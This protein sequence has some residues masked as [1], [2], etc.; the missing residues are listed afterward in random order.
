MKRIAVLM[1]AALLA[2]CTKV[3][4]SVITL[5]YGSQ[6]S[7]GHPF[8]RADITW[9][10]FVEAESGGAV[11]IKPYWAGGL[12]SADE[13]MLEVRHGVVDIGLVTPIYLRAGA[14]M[15]RT[16]AGFYGG[17]RGYADQLAVYRCIAQE[18][19]DFAHETEGLK[20]FAVQGGNLP[21]V[22]T[23]S[24]P[25]RSLADF[26]GLRLRAPV[27]LTPVLKQLGA[28]PV[29]MPM[30]EVYSA[31]A[32]GVIDGVVAPAD[33]LQSLHFNEVT[34]HFSAARFARGAYP[35]RAMSLKVWDALPASARDVLERSIPVWEEAMK[36]E[37]TAAESKGADFG[38]RE[39]MD[40]VDFPA[41]DQVKLD[42]IYNASALS[43]SR[44]FRGVAG[45]DAEAVWRR[46]QEIIAALKS[47]QDVSCGEPAP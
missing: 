12:L 5:S 8:S 15:L 11:V 44:G 40:F 17:S 28:D 36:T 27:E 4:E 47:G 26:R 22:L 43:E 18:F 38:R 34:R 25:V 41:A 30:G 31:L 42:E 21:G 7:P 45:T 23:R 16:Q 3:D 10:K 14:H 24:K 20:V 6:Y 19:P 35:A 37:I 2:A 9:M 1:I 39:G 33:T 32:K 13:S 46:A 29:N